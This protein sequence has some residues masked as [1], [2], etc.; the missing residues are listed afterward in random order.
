MFSK[1]PCPICVAARPSLGTGS[2]LLALMLLPQ[3]AVVSPAFAQSDVSKPSAPSAAQAPGAPSQQAKAGTPLNKEG[4]IGLIRGLSS[5]I[6]V[7]KVV[8]PR[9]KHGIYLDSKGQ[10]DQ[11]KAQEEL[12]ENGPAINPGTPV[13]ITKIDFKAESLTLEINGGGKNG[14][15]WYQH[16]EVG[17]GSTTQPVAAPQNENQTL[18]YGSYVTL[19]FPG[20]VPDLT[21]P[22]AKQLLAPALDFER[23]S[24]TVLYSPAVP[25]KYKEAI[26]NHE[27]V[28]GMDHDAV[29]SAKGPP[30]RK[31]R[32]DQ[33]DGSSKE[34]WIYGLPPHVLF[35][36]FD[37]DT[38]VR[39]KQY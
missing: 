33:A 12:K 23:H 1:V 16:I 7:S 37:G 17:M 24:P 10:I 28:V 3:S 27:V 39:V 26:K 19:K 22:Q 32:E 35:V 34:D 9:G 4:E 30:D 2:L 21:V 15:H 5:E 29:L 25:P 20:R 6:A 18:A 11:A 38:V 36:T 8:L 31:V 13:K 14:K